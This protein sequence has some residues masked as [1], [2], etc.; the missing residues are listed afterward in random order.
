MTLLLK[1]A[2]RM[3]LQKCLLWKSYKLCVGS[4]SYT[5]DFVTANRQF[6]WLEISLVY[7]KREHKALIYGNY[8]VKLIVKKLGKVKI[9]NFT[10]TYSISSSLGNS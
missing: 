4:K 1:K 2:Y 10:N 9:G 3:R 6:D 5:T 8:N 7:K